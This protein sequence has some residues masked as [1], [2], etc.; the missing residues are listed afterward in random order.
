MEVR[1]PSTP[2][3]LFWLLAFIVLLLLH[4][5]QKSLCCA[6][7]HKERLALL[8]IKQQFN[9]F[10]TPHVL[11]SW[12]TL[13]GDEHCCS[14]EGV[15]CDPYTTH[16]TE[17]SLGMLLDPDSACLTQDTPIK[18]WLLNMT[19]FRDF[20][21]LRILDL[22]MNCIGALI[23][24][25]VLCEFRELQVLILGSNKINGVIP[26]CI[27]NLTSLQQLDL[28]EN[29]FN[30]LIPPGLCKIRGLEVL[31]IPGNKCIGNLTSIEE[32]DIS[33]N[34]FIGEIPSTISN[35][36]SLERLSMSGNFFQ[37]KLSL[38]LMSN[39]SNLKVLVISDVTFGIETEDSPNWKP[40]FQLEQVTLSGCNLN[41]NTKTFPKFLSHQN[42]ISHIDLSNNSLSE[43]FPTSLFN[44]KS[45]LEVLVLS[46]NSLI[47]S[48]QH[49]LSLPK[50]Q[51]LD[52]SENMLSGELPRNFGS[53]LSSLESMSLAMNN[54]EGRIPDSFGEMKG[55][56]DLEL[57]HNNFSGEVPRKLFQ[58]CNML[59]ALGLSSNNLGGQVIPKYMN[60]PRLND[61]YLDNN[62]FNGTIGDALIR[63][64]ELQA[65]DLSNNEVG[66][67]I[68]SWIGSFKQLVLL[69]MTQNKIHGQIPTAICNLSSLFYLDISKNRLRG[70]IPSCNGTLTRLKYLHLRD[71]N[72]K[73]NVPHELSTNSDLVAL[74]L[75]NNQL[76]GGIPLWIDQLSSL[77]VLQLGNNRLQGQIPRQLCHL[78]HLNIMDVSS[79]GIS[80]I[81]PSCLKDLSFGTTVDIHNGFNSEDNLELITKDRY[82]YYVGQSIYQM[83]ALDLSCNNLSGYIPLE[84]GGLKD[85]HNLNL[86]SNNLIGSIPET[87]SKLREVESL[88]LSYNNLSGVIPPELVDLNFLAVFNVSYNNLSG[89]VPMAG[90]FA[91]F[92][93]YNYLGNPFLSGYVQGGIRGGAQPPRSPFGEDKVKDEDQTTFDLSVF[94]WSF[95]AS[96]VTFFLAVGVV[97]YIN[98]RW[99]NAWFVFMDVHFL[100]F[101]VHL[102]RRRL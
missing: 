74:D 53:M 65:L 79:N 83:S 4:D 49:N 21:T 90:Q 86:S 28:S 80:G 73:G 15:T 102:I 35:L 87:F 3:S 20:E 9:S 34:Q 43:S 62:H 69:S 2:Y 89:R 30:G 98:P 88:D 33:S 22:S 59:E 91:N 16:V 61:L 97:L 51:I 10:S 18:P 56:V 66:G 52:L 1:C 58:G 50:L 40:S 82:S 12:T 37:G 99:C 29:Q 84:L 26:K 6:C 67:E 14:W 19:A 36:T 27:G 31:Y 25:E 11:S 32:L 8:Q 93:V 92:E 17:L 77:V 76:S 23:H 81:I 64:S 60:L 39:L 44:N 96:H 94:L 95:V 42:L 71:N 70:R 7:I 63:S 47:G 46:K 101:F 85:I 72:L 13:G 24:D 57:S 75:R 68:L 41:N 100:G 55:M 54:F 5:P 48:L 78:L 38:S 45:L